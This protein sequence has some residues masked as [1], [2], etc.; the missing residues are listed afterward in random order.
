MTIQQDLQKKIESVNLCEEYS[1]QKLKVLGQKICQ[2]FDEDCEVRKPW[3]DKQ[4]QWLKLATQVIEKKT[5]PWP[6]A[7]NVKFATYYGCYAVCCSCL[8]CSCAWS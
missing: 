5:Y 6:D 1:D 3:Y 7:A 2:W 4:E 8:S